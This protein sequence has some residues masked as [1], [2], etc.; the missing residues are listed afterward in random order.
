MSYTRQEIIIY[1]IIFIIIVAAVAIYASGLL[2]NQSVSVSVRL[3]QLNPSQVTYPYQLSKFRIYVNNTGNSQVKNLV[4][5]TY[6]NGV[7]LQTFTVQ[8]PPNTGTEINFSYDTY[9]VNGT[10]KFQAVAD[11]GHLLDVQNRSTTSSS[12][13]VYVSPPQVPDVY[14]SMPN[15]N[16][17]A[18][19]HFSFLQ[20]GLAAALF[21]SSEYKNQGL[22]TATTDNNSKLLFSTFRDLLASGTI[23][24]TAGAYTTYKN[25]SVAYTAWIQ[26]AANLSY[27]Y[28][29]ASTFKL[30]E[31]NT[32]AN[33]EKTLYV[34][35]NNETSFCAKYDR[36]WTKIFEYAN[37]SVSSQTCLNLASTNYN[38]TIT[39]KTLDALTNDT[40]LQGYFYS[41]STAIGFAVTAGNATG[42]ME[43]VGNK[44]G[45]FAG[46]V[47]ENPPTFN[48]ISQ[49][50][51]CPGIISVAGKASVCTN[52]VPALNSSNLFVLMNS[53]AFNKNHTY[54]MYSLINASEKSGAGNNAAALLEYL[55]VSG[56]VQWKSATPTYFT[57]LLDN[58]SLPCTYKNFTVNESTGNAIAVVGLKNDFQSFIKLDRIGCR[59]GFYNENTTTNTIIP[60]GGN[61]TVQF[62]C[63]ASALGSLVLPSYV[64]G[65]NYTLGNNVHEVNGTL[66]A[67]N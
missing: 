39:S 34:R 31:Q 20:G 59:L 41:N 9:P 65:I 36:G 3:E 11:P 28:A 17:S 12:Y 61:A 60:A 15:S 7:E 57:C 43:M 1:A 63:L 30:P 33:G 10:Y 29:I 22:F 37:A 67:S 32:T 46:Y 27:V 54:T 4:L 51:I 44:Y 38:S 47:R 35:I 58:T 24:A 40:A 2:S 55:N 5:E 52:E 25:S 19:Q 50:S 45:I 56:L 66:N 8:L 13:S 26:G 64:L 49:N 42:A 18:T 16:I 21:L 53:T 14:T 62:G 23:N 6:V 48:A